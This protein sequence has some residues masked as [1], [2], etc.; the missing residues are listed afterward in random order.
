MTDIQSNPSLLTP[1]EELENI[2]IELLL[3]GIFRVYGYDFRD[4]AFSSLRRRIWHRI[5]ALHLGSVS[6]LQEKVLHDPAQMKALI[7]SLSI[8]VTEMFRDPLLFQLF[9]REAVPYLKSLP[10]IR[11]W[12]AGC[13][14]GEEVLSMAILLHE[15]G[16]LDRARI[17]ATDMN[18]DSLDQARKGIIPLRKMR[19]YTR[20]YLAAGGS[21]EFSEYYSVKSEYAVFQPELLNHAVFAQ[22]NLVTDQSF[23][24][25]HVIFCRNVLIY[26]NK[27]LQDQVHRLIYDSLS[28]KG[29]LALGNRESINFT[30]HADSYQP[31]SPS[32]RLYRKIR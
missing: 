13:S 8:S 9:R 1:E 3:E 23:N 6:G 12:H 28:L 17:Y 26:F 16:L 7:G 14:T 22:H 29:F 27:D 31:M 11:I 30:H 25:F 21:G 20:N 18:E 4:Y 10:Q 19:D 15:E 2:E 32:E 24:E 5:H